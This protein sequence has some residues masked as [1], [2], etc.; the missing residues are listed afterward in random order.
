MKME[1]FRFSGDMS[2]D[3]V[4]EFN[5]H[6]ILQRDYA[7]ILEYFEIKNGE[8]FP[9]NKIEFQIYDNWGNPGFTCVYRLRVHGRRK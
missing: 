9:V 2:Q 4:F 6:R 5:P 3:G 7:G 8:N 1:G